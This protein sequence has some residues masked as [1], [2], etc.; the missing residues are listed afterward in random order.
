MSEAREWAESMRMTRPELTLIGEPLHKEASLWAH[1]TDLGECLVRV[2][3]GDGL[4]RGITIPHG[5]AA[6]LGVFLVRVFSEPSD[7]VHGRPHDAKMA[8]NH[9]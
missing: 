8:E 7:L 5:Y 4:T 9:E 6:V 3:A 2:D 1:V